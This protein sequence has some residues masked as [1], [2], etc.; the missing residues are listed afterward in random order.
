MAEATKPSRFQVSRIE[1]DPDRLANAANATPKTKYNAPK[2]IAIRNHR[3]RLEIS[4]RPADY[5][6]SLESARHSTPDFGLMDLI[7]EEK[8]VKPRSWPGS[9]IR[10]IIY[11]T[12]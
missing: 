10:A 6:V 4:M 5:L 8:A 9:R 3:L 12:H 7:I 2:S 11:L 1:F